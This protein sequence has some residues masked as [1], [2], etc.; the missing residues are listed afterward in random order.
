MGFINEDKHGYK[1]SINTLYRL[2]VVKLYML[3]CSQVV[4]LGMTT[5]ERMNHGR[6]TYLS[7]NYSQTRGHGH[8][9][10]EDK[11]CKHRVKN[12]FE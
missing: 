7:G 10:G 12:P 11:E 5:N 8:S 9:H 3:S 1:Y 4:W 6:Y 2:L